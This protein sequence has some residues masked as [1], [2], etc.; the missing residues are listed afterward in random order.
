MYTVFRFSGGN[1]PHLLPELGAKL[2]LIIPGAFSGLDEEP[3][4]FSCVVCS[5]PKLNE[6]L[7]SVSF[8]VKKIK[9]IIDIAV[10][11][12]MELEVDIALEPGDQVQII[13]FDRK[14]L[15]LL[16]Q[17]SVSLELTDYRK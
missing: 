6:H 13:R 2:N 11:S 14:F 8:F 1:S 17:N 5:D 7:L 9:T 15:S 12:G 16:V 4:R 3:N 10:I